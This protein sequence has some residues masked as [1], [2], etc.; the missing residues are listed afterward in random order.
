MLSRSGLLVAVSLTALAGTFMSAPPAGAAAPAT[1]ASSNTRAL[2]DSASE[3]TESLAGQVAAAFQH[4]VVVA[5]ETT[6]T[7]ETSAL[8]DG[9]M[10]LV[11]NTVPVRVR[12]STG[13]VPVNAKLAAAGDGFVAPAATETAVEFSAGN[14][15]VLAKVRTHTGKWL[16]ITSPF[17]SL[18]VP[19][20]SGATATYANVIAG[21]DLKLTATATGMSDVLVI[22]SAAAAANPALGS[23]NF[24]LSGA[25]LAPLTGGVSA[26]KAPDG[27]SLVS[28]SP[29][30]WD[31]SDGSDATGP[32]GLNSAEPVSQTISGSS[33]S[34]NA[35]AATSSR[36]V[37]Y[38]VYVDPDFN[39]S[40]PQAYTYVDQAYTSQSYWDGNLAG[41]YLRMGYITAA[42]SPDKK[43]HLSRALWQMSTAGL[44]GKHIVTANLNLT[45]N[46][47]FNCTASQVDLYT[48]GGISSGTTWTNQPGI[49]Q[50][51]ST[52]TTAHGY[53]SAC[54]AA[55]VGFSVTTGVAA[56]AAASQSSI[57][58]E[59][60]AHL[61]N[62]NTYYKKWQE[63]GSMTVTYHSDPNQPSSP[64]IASPA[65]ACGTAAAP[66]AVPSGQPIVMQAN[67]TDP[68]PVNVAATFS[69]LSGTSAT[70][71][72][73]YSSGAPQAQGNLTATIPSAALGAGLYRW[74][75]K[76]TDGT[77]TSLLASTDCY[78][79]IVTSAPA[80]PTVTKTSTGTPNVGLPMTVTF[81]S[82]ITDGV[83]VFAY[84]WV[85][86][87]STVAPAP[88]VLTPIN[89]AATL[90]ACGSAQGS[91]R[92]VCP[93]AG[94]LSATGVTVAPID[95]TSTLWVASYN[96]AGKVSVSSGSTYGA[97]GLHVLTS[98]D[99]VGVSNTV[100][101]V[102]DSQSITPAATA[103]PDL[104]TTTGTTGSTTRQTLG[105]PVS[106]QTSGFEGIPT[107][108]MNFTTSSTA[109]QTAREA[110]D[111]KNSFTV[112]AWVYLSPTSSSSLAH[113]AV[114]E[115]GNPNNVP[116][117]FTLGTGVGDVL[118][119][120][121]TRQIDNVQACAVGAA[122]AK[123]KWTLITGV[124]DS[125]NQSLR[126][127]TN[128]SFGGTAYAPQTAPTGDTSTNSW[129]CV[130]GAC[131]RPGG[132][133]MATV[134]AWDG[135]IFRP[136]AFPGVISSAQLANL[137]DVLSP[138][139]DP[140]T[141]ESIGAVVNLGCDDL[142]TPQNIYD[143]NPNFTNVDFT[144][145]AGSSA[146]Q[147]EQW[148]GLACEWVNDTSN[149]TIDVSV[150]NI[151]DLGTMVQLQN[152]AAAG[153]PVSGIGD[154]AY[155]TMVTPSEGELQVFS[156]SYWLT[157]RSTWFESADDAAPLPAD[158]LS[159]LPS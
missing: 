116:A 117:A 4:P 143:Y 156:G 15:T 72:G 28:S 69:V 50:L 57:T 137:Y 153:T 43:N 114:S 149:D 10:Q 47:S 19:T 85:P 27:S 119:F 98:D 141:D 66:A 122:L 80:L 41:G 157:F 18:P 11:E 105:T 39:D 125:A 20:L 146:A 56:A 36:A 133:G 6:S 81:G 8:P 110:V 40:S 134:Q 127:L 7:N 129:F 59:A 51:Q 84:W 78:F 52:A 100:G 35:T 48:S 101:H 87:N 75:A 73:T 120:C 24:K 32:A 49:I 142:L 60:R 55:A 103:V 16:Q 96:V 61:E 29:T 102:W 14:S 67:V 144:P 124:W 121:R 53:S 9:T 31:S 89:S 2:V 63:S 58:F 86:T 82:A 33:I 93:A 152:S 111:T 123:G 109:A 30:W 99:T 151:Q 71:V 92:F 94:T 76:A 42:Y 97:T 158:A 13:W 62:S 34:L 54:P 108:V 145:A 132:T 113:V 88:P 65:R 25:T 147:A 26:A 148:N 64:T 44:A 135:Q 1:S 136:S 106:L 112:S 138:N 77:Y 91:V 74:N 70:V 130:G 128:G 159:N 90:P 21:V 37:V 3:P 38:P 83:A 139:D 150:A 155:F 118:T 22:H 5:S 126:L 68:D 140:P 12:T 115:Y 79:E 154:S 45:E 131:T 17:G 46:G 23:V 104:N 95:D 107:T